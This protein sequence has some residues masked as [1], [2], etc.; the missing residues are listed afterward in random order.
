MTFSV[1]GSCIPEYLNQQALGCRL[2]DAVELLSEAIILIAEAI[3]AHASDLARPSA[4]IPLRWA[5][6]RA[7]GES[8]RTFCLEG[9]PKRSTLYYRRGRDLDR[10]AAFLNEQRAVFSLRP[11]ADNPL[12]GRL[13]REINVR[14]ALPRMQADHEVESKVL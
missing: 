4:E 10:V 14:K 2:A 12:P 3:I 9:G 1:S 11:P 5:R 6:M 8:I 7:R 13:P